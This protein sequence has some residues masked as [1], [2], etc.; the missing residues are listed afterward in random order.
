MNNSALTPLI[1]DLLTSPDSQ[2]IFTTVYE[3]CTILTHHWSVVA[4]SLV[5]ALG[6]TNLAHKVPNEIDYPTLHLIFK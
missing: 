2:I 1:R 4:S 5:E 6:T 3:F